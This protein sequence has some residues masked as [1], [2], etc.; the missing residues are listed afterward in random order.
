MSLPQ[1]AAAAPQSSLQ[2]PSPRKSRPV[3]SW[4][5]AFGAADLL[6][7][8]IAAALIYKQGA[9]LELMGIAPGPGNLLATVGITLLLTAFVRRA[10]GR[11]QSALWL[12]VTGL[13]SLLLYADVVYYRQFGDLI[14]VAAIRQAHQLATVGDSVTALIQPGDLWLFADLPIL[15]ALLFLP[16]TAVQ[17]W[18]A[19]QSWPVVLGAAVAGLVVA[20]GVSST[21][22]LMSAKYYGHSNVG[23]RLG[24]L[25]YHAFDVAE[26]TGKMAVRLKPQTREIA[27]IQNWFAAKQKGGGVVLASGDNPGPVANPFSGTAAGRNVIVL[28]LESYQAFPL[29]M[30]IA[31]QE[32]TPNLNRLMGE[33]LRFPNFYTQTGQGVTSDADLLVNCSLFPTRTGA[34]YYDYAGNDFRCLPNVLQQQGYETVA[35]QGIAPDFWNLAAV[36]P[37]IGFDRYESERAYDMSETIG[38]GVSDESFLRQSVAKL[39]ALPEPYYAFLVTLTSHGP[40]DYENLPH[41]LGLGSLEGTKAGNYL[42][43]MHYTDKAVGQ[44]VDQLKAEGLLNEA[45]LVVYGDHMGV[46]RN[47]EAMDQLGLAENAVTWTQAEKRVPLMIRL[48]EGAHAG[49]YAEAAGQADLAPTI[50]GLLGLPANDA[51]FMGRDLLATDGGVVPFYRSSAVDDTHLYFSPDDVSESEGGQCYR[52]DTGAQTDLSECESLRNRSAEQLRISR[53]LVERNLIPAVLKANRE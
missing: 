8:A 19:R 22:P 48:P 28:Q 34:V 11:W 5:R 36:Y 16:K 12:L 42:Q 30:T 21:D 25:N 46:S 3:K 7:L 4:W 33:S 52:L 32:V 23:S 29:G 39:K 20:V 37:R 24:L 1:Q 10:G 35:M 6:H 49:E 9:A 17:R 13:L 14:S 43:A 2:Q 44:F 41:E 26:Y 27:E 51:L 38:L 45:V 31:G 47:D 53:L 18:F 15:A 50:G 40:F